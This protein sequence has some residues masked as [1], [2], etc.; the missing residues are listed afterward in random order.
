MSIPSLHP[1]QQKYCRWDV[2]SLLVKHVAYWLGCETAPSGLKS[3]TCGPSAASS[4]P[5]Y[6]TCMNNCLSCNNNN[7]NR[8]LRRRRR[9]KQQPYSVRVTLDSKADKPV[10]LIY[11]SNWNL[12]CRTREKTLGSCTI[13][14]ENQQQTQP[15]CDAGP[16]HWGRV[17]SPL[18][19]PCIP[20]CCRC[21]SSCVI[22]FSPK[23]RQGSG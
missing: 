5:D 20:R 15:T 19:H 11:G 2:N 17:L 23:R 12:E 9:H 8:H 18:R 10:A 22:F 21:C 4:V 16:Q 14:E 13:R 6:S 1:R 7:N 3:V